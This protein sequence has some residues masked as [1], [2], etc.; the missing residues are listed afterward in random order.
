MDTRSMV[1]AQAVCVDAEVAPLGT[2][3]PVA[4]LDASFQSRR[5]TRPDLPRAGSLMA[6][7]Y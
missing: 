2:E 7:E 5:R 6:R 3:A 4:S 1:A